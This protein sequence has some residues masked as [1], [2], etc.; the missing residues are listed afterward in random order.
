MYSNRAYVHIVGIFICTYYKMITIKH[1]TGTKGVAGV[2]AHIVHDH[3]LRADRHFIENHSTTCCHC[4]RWQCHCFCSLPRKISYFPTLRLKH[5]I[6][7]DRPTARDRHTT[8]GQGNGQTIERTY[9]P[10]IFQL[11]SFN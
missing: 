1:W 7:T 2:T 8:N 5:L 4:R 10:M 9:C 11:I 3:M 6:N